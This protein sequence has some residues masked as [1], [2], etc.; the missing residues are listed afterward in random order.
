MNP[1]VS[2]LAKAD[3]EIFCSDLSKLS[4]ETNYFPKEA[5]AYYD[6]VYSQK[7]IELNLDRLLILIVKEK[8]DIQ[9]L[10]LGSSPEGGVGTII[11]L[12]VKPTVQ[13]SGLGALLFESAMD[14]YRQRGCHKV[15]LTVPK[16]EVVSFYE[17]QGMKLEGFH[18]NH[19]WNMDIWSMGINLKN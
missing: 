15:K 11:W 18:P 7:Q 6:S 17:K 19:W 14:E 3:I 8:N 13:K 9:G 4:Q 10:L 2:K 16:K 12:L 5:L 1:K